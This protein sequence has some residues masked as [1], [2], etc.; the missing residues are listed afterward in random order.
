MVYMVED[1]KSS[2]TTM[3][4]KSFSFHEWIHS[5]KGKKVY[6]VFARDDPR[7]F[8]VFC[9]DVILSLIKQKK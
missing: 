3:Q 6:A 1:I 4:K 5:Y 7:P 2:L 9:S 8:V